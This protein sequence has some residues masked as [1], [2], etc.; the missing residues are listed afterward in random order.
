MRRAV[1][2]T[3][4]TVA[5]L[6]ALLGYRSSGTVNVQRVS[7]GTAPGPSATTSPGTTAPLATGPGTTPTTL[8]RRP[9]RR[10]P[11]VANRQRRQRRVPMT[12]SSLRTST[13]ISRWP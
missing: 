13:A 11:L 3:A 6:V 2:A 12:D 7:V 4:G 10:R 8:A 1:I 5:G 9:R